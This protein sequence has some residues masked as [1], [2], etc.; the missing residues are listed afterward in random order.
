METDGT[1]GIRETAGA[2][3]KG[4][5]MHSREVLRIETDETGKCEGT[6]GRICG[7]HRAGVIGK[8]PRKNAVL[9]LL[10]LPP[11]FSSGIANE[12]DDD[13]NCLK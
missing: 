4:R 13:N 10:P 5:E 12:D 7:L 6:G 3:A 8:S 11:P 9:V 1:G 2:G